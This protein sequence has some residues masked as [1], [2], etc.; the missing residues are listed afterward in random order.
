MFICL[1]CG[2]LH[3]FAGY[4]YGYTLDP[5]VVLTP[6]SEAAADHRFLVQPFGDGRTGFVQLVRPTA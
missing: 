4:A 6:T 2:E 1:T 5:Y 3:L